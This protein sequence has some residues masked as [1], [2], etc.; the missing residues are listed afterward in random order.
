MGRPQLFFG[1]FEDHSTDISALNGISFLIL[2]H[3]E[4][5]SLSARFVPTE[6]DTAVTSMDGDKSHRHIVFHFS[7]LNRL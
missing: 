5:V 4:V 6:V 7:F 2:L 3:G 1:H